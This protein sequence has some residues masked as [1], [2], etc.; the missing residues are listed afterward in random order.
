MTAAL[1]VLSPGLL[2]TVQDLGRPGY[3]QLGIP[4]SGALDPVGLRAA[5]ALAGNPPDIGA[6]EVVH[7][8]PTFG[9][10]APS[11]RMSFA[12]AEAM[13][14]VFSDLGARCGSPVETMRSIRLLRGEVIR[15]GA[16]SRGAL[17]YVAVEGGFAIAP[18]LGSVSTY[19]RGGLGGWHGRA[20]IEGDRLPL[21]RDSASDRDECRL[22]GIDLSVP[23]RLRAVDGPQIDHFTREQIAAFFDGEYTV[24]GGDRMGMRLHGRNLSHSQGFDII[25]D[26]VAPGS[27]Q[28]SG[29]GQP[30]VLLADRQTTGG[31]PKIATVIS[32]DLP[33]LGRVP[34]GAKIG[35]ERIAIAAAAALRRKLFAEI[36]GISSRIVPLRSA[37]DRAPN[38]LQLNLIS[39]VIDARN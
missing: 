4:G 23:R 27:I 3:A 9:I 12:G 39:G 24:C 32:A 13:I 2:T 15:I 5:N 37:G 8:G 26:G 36:D 29:S 30:I 14:E 19:I 21:C 10:D 31:Y 38:L 28:I 33:A 6:L 25:S 34:I 35:F 18:V 11:V 16:L 20:L 7:V 22:D 1:R 17:L